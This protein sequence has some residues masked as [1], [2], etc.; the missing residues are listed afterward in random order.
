[1]NRERLKNAWLWTKDDQ[2]SPDDA[3]RLYDLFMEEI[4]PHRSRFLR[5]P[6]SCLFDGIAIGFKIGREYNRLQLRTV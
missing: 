2:I 3:A 1:M 6:I 4:L 5:D